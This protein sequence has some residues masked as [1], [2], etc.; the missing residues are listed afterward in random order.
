MELSDH[1]DLTLRSLQRHPLRTVLTMLGIIIGVASIVAM[2]SIGLGAKNQIELEISKLGTNLLMVM[3]QPAGPESANSANPGPISLTEQDAN[4]I[5]QAVQHIQY[6][7]PV[8]R[9]QAMIIAGKHSHTTSAVGTL[10]SYVSA[11][12]WKIQQG[13]NFTDSENSS[14][15]KVLVI[16]KTV[17]KKIS[18]LVSPLGKTVRLQGIPVKILG[19]LEDKG[20]AA[21]GIDQDD[22]AIMPIKTLK[23]RFIGDFYSNQRDAVHFILVKAHPGAKTPPLRHNI[24]RTIRN[25]HG[26]KPDQKNDFVIRDPT[27]TLATQKAAS[28]AM[29]LLL[30]CVSAV[31]LVVGGISVMNIM[32]VS[33]AERTRE[34]GIR[35]AVGA[36]RA[37]ILYQFLWEASAVAVIGGLTGIVVGI[38]AAYVIKMNTGWQISIS[39]AALMLSL[40]FSAVVGLVA[41]IYPAYKASKLNAIDALRH[42]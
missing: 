7:V 22:I 32:L 35:I 8:V 33:V 14:S 29:T 18:P 30:G 2:V 11:R 28:R 3:P 38:T 21:S 39:I 36:Q 37:H 34:I 26:L 9:G 1:I 12:D 27:A 31:S 17:V 41:G 15:A 6:T 42:E 4:A 23:T 10:P 19:I 13:R 5:K 25:L 40:L 24:D 16:G 20:F